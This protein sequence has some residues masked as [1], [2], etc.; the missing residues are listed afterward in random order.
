MRFTPQSGPRRAVQVTTGLTGTFEFSGIP[1]GKITLAAF[2][3]VSSGV[4][5]FAGSIASN[6]QRVVVGDLV[7]DNTAPRVVSVDPPDRSAGVTLQ[8][9]MLP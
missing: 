4:R 7:L 8:P 3:L 6:G 1:V 9:A 5:T 2:E